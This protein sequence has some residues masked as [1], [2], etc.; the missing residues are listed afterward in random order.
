MGAETVTIFMKDDDGFVSWQ[1]R[2]TPSFLIEEI[3]DSHSII[4]DGMK[5]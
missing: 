2:A 4:P 5:L 1:L 3:V